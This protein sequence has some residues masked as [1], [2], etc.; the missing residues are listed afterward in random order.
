MT[1][2]VLFEN[3]KTG[4]IKPM[5]L[6]EGCE[7]GENIFNRMVFKSA[8]DVGMIDDASLK[9]LMTEFNLESEGLTRSEVV[10]ALWKYISSTSTTLYGTVTPSEGD[11]Q[12]DG[13][14]TTKAKA[15]KAPK[16]KKAKKAAAGDG[17]GRKSGFAG[18]K[19]YKI[20]D[21]N[22]RREGSHGFNSFALIKNGMTYET[23][24]AGGGRLQDLT[25][26]VKHGH[27]EVRD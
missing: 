16:E 14:M 25:W 27:V 24:I 9:R 26:D 4:A 19:L 10:E 7:P 12:K 1:Q 18:K 5:I 20:A 6:A 2:Y 22:P 17:A 13:D 11:D 23:Y 3:I 8:T 21:K 15:K